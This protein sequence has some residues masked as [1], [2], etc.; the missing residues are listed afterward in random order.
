MTFQTGRRYLKAPSAGILALLQLVKVR[1][2]IT[3]VT[4]NFDRLVEDVDGSGFLVM[5][6]DE[7]FLKGRKHLEEYLKTGEGAV[8]LLSCMAVSIILPTIVADVETT[9]LGLSG[10]K[11]DALSLLVGRPDA[12]YKGVYVG[13]STPDPDIIT[14]LGARR[15]ADGTDERWVAPTADQNVQ[16]VVNISR[17]SVLEAARYAWNVA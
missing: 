9:A 10:A 8:P 14:E 11:A 5:R 2:R 3:I 15:F 6:S 17:I 13:Y 1:A 16:Q 4:V 12:R 7:E